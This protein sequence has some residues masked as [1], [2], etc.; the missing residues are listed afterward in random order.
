M[1]IVGSYTEIA[2]ED[3]PALFELLTSRTAARAEE[4]RREVASAPYGPSEA[5]LDYSRESLVPLWRWVLVWYDE[6]RTEPA[7]GVDE[8]AAQP[9][10]Y[11][12]GPPGATDPLGDPA[13]IAVV[14]GVA[15]YL[16]EVFLRTVPETRWGI[17]R[18]PRRQRYVDQNRP[19]LKLGPDGVDVNPLRI[20]HVVLLRVVLDGKRDPD[21]LLDVYDVRT[22]GVLGGAA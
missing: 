3:A 4:F 9:P 21:E 10:W 18:M 2:D 6:H 11:E 20:A 14:D 22:A 15:C 13:L 5:E 19:V 8:D 16:A 17:G 7:G 12:P 1:P